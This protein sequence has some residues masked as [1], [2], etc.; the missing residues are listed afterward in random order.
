[1]SILNKILFHLP[2][3]MAHHLSLSGLNVLYQSGCLRSPK[4]F[5]STI[6]VMGLSFPSPIGIAAGLDKNADYIDALGVLG[7]GFIE[8]GT[9]TPK[10][11][12]GNPKPRLFRLE[13]QEALINRMGFN[14]KGLDYVVNRLKKTKYKGILGVNI[15]KNRDTSLENAVNDYVLGFNAVA[16]FA[17]YVTVNLSSPNTPGLRELQHA[18]FLTQLLQKLKQAQ[19]QRNKYVPLVVKIAP[20]LMDAE[21]KSMAAIFLA[22]KIDGVIATNTTINRDNVR[23][24]KFATEPGGLSGKPLSQASTN[25]IRKLHTLV[26]DTIPIIGCGGIFSKQD[27]KEKMDA[28]ASLVQVYTGL[29]YKGFDLI[30]ELVKFRVD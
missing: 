21:L 2:P 8:V 15:G 28:G 9:V 14:N 6:K 25:L 16:P 27:V 30:Q 29:V 4:K 1:M 20:D 18:E 10:A 13:E 5:Q 26:G 17:S 11:Q 22:E 24:A 7:F 23:E 12:L 3:E 19:A